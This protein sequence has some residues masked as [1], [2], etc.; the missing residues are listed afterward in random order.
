MEEKCKN[1]EHDIFLHFIG[2]QVAGVTAQNKGSCIPLPI[3]A[4]QLIMGYHK[5]FS[6][7]R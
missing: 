1:H 7:S 2:S 4:L 3:Y 5:V 6:G